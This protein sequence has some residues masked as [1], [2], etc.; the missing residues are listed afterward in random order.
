MNKIFFI[1]VLSFSFLSCGPSVEVS[2]E[3]PV[4]TYEMVLGRQDN[5][6]QVTE[7]SQPLRSVGHVELHYP[8]GKTGVCSGTL[9]GSRHV[10]TAAHCL[11]HESSFAY[12]VVFTPELL[13]LPGERVHHY[14]AESVW[15]HEDF[16]HARSTHPVMRFRDIPN[17]FAV[18]VLKNQP[19]QTNPG[20]RFGARTLTPLQNLSS[21]QRVNVLVPG[22]PY[23]KGRES[24]WMAPTCQIHGLQQNF[25][26][27]CDT[28]KGM[29]GGPII[30]NQR[31]R[32]YL[33]VVGVN[34]SSIPSQRQNVG[35]RIT[36]AISQAIRSLVSHDLSSARRLFVERRFSASSFSRVYIKNDCHQDLDVALY[37]FDD[38]RQDWQRTSGLLRVPS[39][40]ELRNVVQTRRREIFFVAQTR[41]RLGQSAPRLMWRG[42]HHQSAIREFREFGLAR[43]AFQY[44]GAQYLNFTCPN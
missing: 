12:K 38:D 35:A 43:Q 17:D 7:I 40:G 31:G 14:F 16:Y 19:Q 24:L 29:S 3:T 15:V 44:D 6:V 10:L 26:I 21:N 30:L 39:Q 34:S 8:G 33:S 11:F 28:S 25:S 37:Y 20:Q 32:N 1:L 42:P 36:P 9:I 22:Y 23:E 27:L 41:S 5:R 18:I 2:P 4:S 13:S